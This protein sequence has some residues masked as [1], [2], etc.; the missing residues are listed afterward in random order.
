LVERTPASPSPADVVTTIKWSHSGRCGRRQSTTTPGV[1]RIKQSAP[2]VTL[3]WD[4][5]MD[6]RPNRLAAFPDIKRRV[7]ASQIA[8]WGIFEERLPCIEIIGVS[9]VFGGVLFLLGLGMQTCFIFLGPFYRNR[10]PPKVADSLSSLDLSVRPF[11]LTSVDSPSDART[12]D[13]RNLRAGA[14]Y[15]RSLGF[16]TPLILRRSRSIWPSADHG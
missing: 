8:V 4:G 14:L 7:S 1:R 9:I 2:Q 12:I 3:G 13:R 16:D 5:G 6:I 11:I 15:G 10:A